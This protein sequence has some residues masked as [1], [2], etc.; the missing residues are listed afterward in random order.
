MKIPFIKNF[1]A[2]REMEYIKAA[3][4]ANH[5]QGD[6]R[7]AAECNALLEKIT[8]ARC[9]LI[10]SSCTSGLELAALL[11]DV[12]PRDE[13][14]VPSFTFV[15]TASAFALRGAKIK[16][17]DIRE[18]TLNM[19]E[20]FLKGIASESTKIIAPVHY[21]GVVCDM[22]S[23]METAQKHYSLVIEDAAQAI[24]ASQNGVKVGN[25]GDCACLS[26]FP[27]KNLGGLGDGGM[28]ITNDEA[29]A[30][31][32]RE[33]RNHGMEPKYY[34]KHV[35]GNFRLDALQAA[36][37]LVKLPHLDRWAQMRRANAAAYDEA[38]CGI[39]EIKIPKI[40]PEN[41]SIYNQYIIEVPNRDAVLDA[42]RAADIGCEIYYPL[43]LHLQ[44][45]FSALGYK[46]G[47]FPNSEYAAKHTLALP[48][49]PELP[50]EQLR[51]VAK[52]V[53]DAVA[54]K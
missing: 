40:R 6:G 16:W 42:L 31:R 23:I 35:G 41:Y 52:S 33:I 44:E 49:Y 50:L 11:A 25:F 17:C 45:C 18:D 38:F 20:Q 34:H 29:L 47:D 7:F 12:K 4:E 1:I 2:G 10:V 15:S 43:P 9:A 36:G 51:Y 14:I 30:R 22:A 54:G 13:V 3:V 32:V 8:G 27:S 53:S 24:G 37:L 19:D 39:D 48:I 21:A 5:L 28:V 26:F 46:E